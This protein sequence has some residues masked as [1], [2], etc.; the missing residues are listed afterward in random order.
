DARSFVYI[1]LGTGVGAGI[2]IDGELYRGAR[3]AAGEVGYI[4]WPGPRGKG[5]PGRG[6]LE[7]ETSAAGVIAA[8]KR[9][10]MTG[11][12]NAKDVFDAARR[13]DAKA[14]AA[15]DSEADRVA[16]LVAT[17]TAVVD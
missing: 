10:G 15:V 8:A 4:P 2:V 9:A 5:R 12:P 6:R 13:G 1:G 3:G 14:L 11:S 16:M 17:I 7:E